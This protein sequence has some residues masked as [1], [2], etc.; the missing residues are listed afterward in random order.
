[1]ALGAPWLSP[2]D[3]SKTAPREAVQPPGSRYVLGSDQFGRDVASRVLH[4]ARISLTVGLISVSIALA[5][6]APLGLVSGYYDGRLD[7]LIIRVMDVLPAF[8]A[9]LAVQPLTARPP[10][11]RRFSN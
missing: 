3:P 2:R 5:V 1:M 11:C 8:P 7:A 9:A 4:G 10:R 6:G